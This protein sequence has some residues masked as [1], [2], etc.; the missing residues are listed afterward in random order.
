MD[1][2]K[3]MTEK[4]ICSLTLIMCYHFKNEEQ[5]IASEKKDTFCIQNAVKTK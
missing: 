4:N 5:K 1:D 2:K 3:L